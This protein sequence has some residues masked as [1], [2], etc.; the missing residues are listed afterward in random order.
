MAANNRSLDFDTGG[1]GVLGHRG[2]HGG[3]NGERR[4][5]IRAGIPGS[6]CGQVGRVVGGGRIAVKAEAGWEVSELVGGVFRE[7]LHVDLGEVDVEVERQVGRGGASKGRAGA[8]D[9]AGVIGR[10]VIGRI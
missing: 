6:V 10:V 1:G 8:V 3:D 2:Q 4:L 5:V 7:A 9:G